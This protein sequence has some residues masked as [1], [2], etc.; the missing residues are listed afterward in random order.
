MN[1]AHAQQALPLD[2]ALARVDPDD[3]VRWYEAEHLRL[4]GKGWEDTESVYDRLPAKAKGRVTDTVWGLSKDSSGFA[5]RFSTDTPEV[6]I[7]WTLKKR[8]LAMP[9]MPATGVSGLDLYALNQVDE[10]E[11]VDNGRPTEPT[12][13]A[14]FQVRPGRELLLYFPL[15]NGVTSL[16]IGVPEEA[17]LYEPAASPRDRRKP[18]V[19][20]GTSITQGACAS[21]PG[22]AATAIAGRGLHIPVINLG[23]SGSGKMEIEMAQ[24][25]AELDASIYVL[26][27]IRNMPPD[28]VTE[29]VAPFVRLLRSRRPDTPIVLAEDCHVWGVSPTPKGRILREVFDHLQAEGITN[30]HFLSNRSML[31]EDGEGTVDGIHPNDAG[32]VRQAAVFKA[33]LGEIL[34]NPLSPPGDSR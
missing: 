8:E 17:R 33:F 28:L 1:P 25:V 9:H 18:L 27:C 31:G 13:Q 12:N 19:F 14:A 2:P 15:Y 30:L 22:M 20:Y 21:R 10:W 34:K 32:F 7:R 4:E 23:F 5:V 26:D 16:E 29:R 24:L 11:F 6:R 3:N